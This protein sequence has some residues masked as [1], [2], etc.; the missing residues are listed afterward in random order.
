M[1]IPAELITKPQHPLVNSLDCSVQT[2]IY[3]TRFLLYKD[4]LLTLHF[5]WHLW[6]CLDSQRKHFIFFFWWR[7]L[8]D[9]SYCQ[10]TFDAEQWSRLFSWA[11]SIF[12]RLHLS[13]W[14]IGISI[15]E[16]HTS[17]STCDSCE[18][19]IKL[20]DFTGPHFSQ[21]WKESNR[22]HRFIEL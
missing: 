14:T 21:L 13:W 8:K 4:Q 5:L 10:S 19:D 1:H 7:I 16:A 3:F 17:A 6:L 22:S 9:V 2:Q 18:N 15:E 20:C 11:L 12:P